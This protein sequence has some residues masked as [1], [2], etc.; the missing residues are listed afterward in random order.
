[1]QLSVQ[2]EEKDLVAFNLHY[3]SQ[4][5]TVQAYRFRY[6]VIA[7]AVYVVLA[8]AMYAHEAHIAAAILAIVAV[9]WYLAAPGRLRRAARR[10]I[11]KMIHESSEKYLSAPVTVELRDDGIFSTSAIG[12]SKFDYAAVDHVA[13]IDGYTFVFI[14]KSMG[15]ILP[16]DRVPPDAI[17]EFVADLERRRGLPAA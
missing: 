5:K 3:Q 12:M 8:L 6:R 2:L 7:P 4:S 9:V 10:H 17:R 14:G 13:E 11:E 1:M 16:H 15:F